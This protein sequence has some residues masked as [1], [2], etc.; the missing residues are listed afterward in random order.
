VCYTLDELNSKFPLM[1]NKLVAVNQD[2]LEENKRWRKKAKAFFPFSCAT[3]LVRGS[4]HT[5]CRTS[6]WGL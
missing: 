5:V 2:S 1:S 3:Q 6:G 4:T